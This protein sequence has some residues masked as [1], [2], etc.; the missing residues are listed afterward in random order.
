[1]SR[2]TKK[3]KKKVIEHIELD[4]TVLDIVLLDKAGKPTQ[5]Q[6]LFTATNVY[7]R[8]VGAGFTVEDALASLREWYEKEGKE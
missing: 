7:D 2:K 8:H 4:H 1:M 5:K 3:G 6:Q